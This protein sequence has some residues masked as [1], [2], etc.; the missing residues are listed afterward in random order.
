VAVHN[1]CLEMAY[2]ALQLTVKESRLGRFVK[3]ASLSETFQN[4]TLYSPATISIAL[5]DVAARYRMMTVENTISD[6]LGEA[7][8]T[9]SL[10]ATLFGTVPYCS[11]PPM[12]FP[13]S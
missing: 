1:R 8:L 9:M 10:F 7:L 4:Q 5:Y 6:R 2:Q 12:L 11:F 13:L 3:N